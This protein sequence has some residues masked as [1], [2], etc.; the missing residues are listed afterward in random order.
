MRLCKICQQS[1]EN[2]DQRILCCSLECRDQ[3][4]R[5]R[6]VEA[7]SKRRKVIK[8]RAVAFKGGKCQ[9]CDYATC[10]DALDFHHVEPEHKDFSISDYGHSR[11]WER[12]Q[13]E[14]LKCILV[15]ANCHREI[16]AGLIKLK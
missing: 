6:N 16:H 5:K 8:A 14:L 1:F 12:V 11:S 4:K 10:I 2:K 13:N 9:I 3:Y 7:V 15:C